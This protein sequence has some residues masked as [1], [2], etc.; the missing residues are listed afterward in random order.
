MQTLFKRRGINK[1][2]KGQVIIRMSS[3]DGYLFCKTRLSSHQYNKTWDKMPLLNEKS[4]IAKIASSFAADASCLVRGSHKAA[5]MYSS[6]SQAQGTWEVKWYLLEVFRLPR[7][8]VAVIPHTFFSWSSLFSHFSLL[9]L[10]PCYWLWTSRSNG[11]RS[12]RCWKKTLC[13]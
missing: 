8:L 7:T 6:V 11:H 1:V 10:F 3:C 2:P 5:T 13:G 4:N 9:F 12:C